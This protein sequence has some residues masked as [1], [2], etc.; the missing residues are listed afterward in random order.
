MDWFLDRLIGRWIDSLIDWFTD[1]L[2]DLLAVWF[3]DRS[4]DQNTTL[5]TS[6]PLVGRVV[7]D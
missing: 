5:D 4:I 6:F 1:R 2:T 3:F 7:T